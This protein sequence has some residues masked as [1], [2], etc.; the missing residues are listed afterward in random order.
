MVSMS[1]FDEEIE[2]LEQYKQRT[3]GSQN[4]NG[5]DSNKAI[6]EETELAYTEFEDANSLQR[7]YFASI[8]GID[9]TT[10]VALQSNGYGKHKRLPHHCILP[11]EYN[12]F[13][14]YKSATQFLDMVWNNH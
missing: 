3:R 1:S 14:E 4:K 12:F 13:V 8:N 11:S 7:V 9:E 10:N 2:S 5:I 6:D